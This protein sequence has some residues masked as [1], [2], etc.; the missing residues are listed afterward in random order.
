MLHVKFFR[1]LPGPDDML[2]L[3]IAHS[4]YMKFEEYPRA[5][6]IALYLDNMQVCSY[7]NYDLLCGYKLKT[8]WI[9]LCNIILVIKGGSECDIHASFTR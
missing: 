7:C 1:Y 9:K 4:I 6:Q 5:L 8:I 2:V 3:D